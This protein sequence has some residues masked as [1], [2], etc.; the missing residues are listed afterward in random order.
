[1]EETYGRYVAEV[2]RIFDA[3][4]KRLLPADVAAKGIKI[5]RIGVDHDDRK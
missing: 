1:M 3:N 5:M 2:T 4:A